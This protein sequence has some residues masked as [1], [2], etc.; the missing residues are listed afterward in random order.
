LKGLLL[1]LSVT[2][3]LG[4]IGII[5]VHRTLSRGRWSG[6]VSGLG[7]AAADTFFAG[8]A[9]FGLSFFINFFQKQQLYLMLGGGVTLV[10]LG[11]YLFFSNP[12]NQVRQPKKSTNL[13]SDFF[14]VFFLTISNPITIIFFGAFFASLDILE[15]GSF[16]KTL[17]VIT[18]IFSGCLLWW[19]TLTTLVNMFRRKFHLRR[20]WY[21]NRITSIIIV[22]FGV[23][24]IASIFFRK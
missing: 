15:D 12:A 21:M 22:A 24:T 1:G 2:V 9:G 8:V 20:L 18:G 11:L 4:P 23:I 3:P 17:L 16:D 10:V 6:L 19:F 13:V 14:S 5:C 7:A